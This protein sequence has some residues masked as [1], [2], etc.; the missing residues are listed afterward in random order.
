MSEPDSEL[1]SASEANDE[2]WENYAKRATERAMQ[3]GNRGPVRLDKNGSMFSLMCWTP[4]KWLIWPKN[5]TNY[6]ITHR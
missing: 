1:E 3:L 5:S 4:P 2:T 6:W